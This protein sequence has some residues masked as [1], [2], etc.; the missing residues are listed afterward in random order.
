MEAINEKAIKTVEKPK[1]F[2]I[3]KFH[4][5]KNIKD[6]LNI[7]LEVNSNLTYETFDLNIKD[8]YLAK[9]FVPDICAS[10]LTTNI[11]K[12]IVYKQIIKPLISLRDYTGKYDE[13]QTF[14]LS[15]FICYENSR[16]NILI[17][18]DEQEIQHFKDELVK[19]LEILKS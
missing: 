6:T 9:N 13:I 14:R 8:V 1:A 18:F 3:E 16:E 17:Y 15:E 11:L 10:V 19:Q 2:S 4:I 7:S 5:V 12:E